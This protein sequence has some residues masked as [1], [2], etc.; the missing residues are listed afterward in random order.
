[1]EVSEVKCDDDTLLD[2]LPI[3]VE[4]DGT[5]DDEPPCGVRG[6]CDDVGD[7]DWLI[8]HESG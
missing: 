1:M 8:L 3:T 5:V 4:F 2:V 7:L 6:F